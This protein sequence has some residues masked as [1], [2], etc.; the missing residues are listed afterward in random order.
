MTAYSTSW[1][2]VPQW[3]QN[4]PDTGIETV[5]Y[6]LLPVPFPKPATRIQQAL[7]RLVLLLLTLFNSLS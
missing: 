4:L 1:H 6:C 5:A 7:I 2:Y 3:S